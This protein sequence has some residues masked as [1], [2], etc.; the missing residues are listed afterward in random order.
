MNHPFSILFSSSE[1]RILGLMSGT[2]LDGID[3][4]DVR[5]TGSGDD[6]T[7]HLSA[8]Y[9]VSFS[10]VIK[11]ILLRNSQ[12]E[13]ASLVELTLLG[14]LLAREYEGAILSALDDW[15]TTIGD[16]DAAGVH[17]QTIYHQPEPVLLAGHTLTGTYQVGDPSILS[18]RLGLPV[19]G[20]FR[21][22]DMALGGQGAPLVPYFD[23]VTFRD[24]RE[25]RM[26]INL[27]GIANFTVL[28]A[29]SGV[30]GVFAL[31]T[32]PA[33]M[34]LDFLAKRYLN[35]AFD[36]GGE[37]AMSGSPDATLLGELLDHPFFD[38]KPPRSTGRELFS[39]KYME[40]LIVR[41]GA[42]GLST[43]DLFATVAAF[44]ADSILIAW[45][46]FVKSDL[47]L[48]RILVSGGGVHNRAVMDRL[49]NGFD[50]IPIQTTDEYG[51]DPDMKEA[52][53]F[54]VL[55]HETLNGVPTNVPGA[56][57]AS[58]QTVLG[59]ICLPAPVC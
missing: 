18:A 28:P 51:V 35:V 13:H 11:E 37:M 19:V 7:W 23:Y 2:S 53:C 14:D 44:S 34:I 46:R 20:N 3:I 6:L 48:S 22:A 49:K 27:G 45:E 16:Y 36:A 9:S 43:E 8:S 30:D 47:P 4:A 55:A 21:A 5:I 26:L 1:R 39:A 41:A 12:P 59:T 42:L 17:G 24:A 15:G 33:N 29:D 31:D 10:D 32:G 57:G 52:I 58:G 56:T 25:N 38:R 50:P 54:A 40:E